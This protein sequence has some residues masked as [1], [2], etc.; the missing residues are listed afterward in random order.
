MENGSCVFFLGCLGH[1]KVKEVN[2]ILNQFK[3]CCL[4]TKNKHTLELSSTLFYKPTSY[5]PTSICN[6][7]FSNKTSFS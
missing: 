7:T 4:V 2:E 3:N 1:Q 5:K 6:V